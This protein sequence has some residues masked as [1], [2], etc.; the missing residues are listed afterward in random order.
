MSRHHGSEEFSW[1]NNELYRKDTLVARIEK[2]GEQ[3]K[4]WWIEFPAGTFS[5]DY[6]NKSRA[7]DNAIAL[8]LTELNAEETC[9]E[10]PLVRLNKKR[11]QT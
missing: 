7:K 2:D 5:A 8:L 10:A 3:K 11:I 9:G 4:M 6:Y 1:K